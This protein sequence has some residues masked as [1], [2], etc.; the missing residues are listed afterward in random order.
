[1]RRGIDEFPDLLIKKS[2]IGWGVYADS[3]IPADVWLGTYSG[4]VGS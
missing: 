3:D 4:I 2:E 1:M